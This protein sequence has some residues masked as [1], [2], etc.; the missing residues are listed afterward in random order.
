M[1]SKGDERPSTL[2]GGPERGKKALVFPLPASEH[3]TSIITYTV[4][5]RT[6]W[7]T[8]T[9]RVHKKLLCRA[10]EY[11]NKSLN[12]GFRERSEKKL[13]L[14]HDCPA[15]FEV[16]YNWV[17]T[18]FFYE[19]TKSESDPEPASDLYYLEIY[20]FADCRLIPHLKEHV[21]LLL[22]E[23]YNS[24]IGYLPCPIFLERL[25][26][27]DE[28][29]AFLRDYFVGHTAFW[30]REPDENNDYEHY[31]EIFQA[32]EVKIAQQVALRLAFWYSGDSQAKRCHP[33]KEPAFEEARAQAK[34]LGYAHA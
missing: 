1:S 9:F 11:F 30:L 31:E 32:C 3:C 19:E 25:F 27:I 7:P 10:S 2:Q 13:E 4:G 15:A 22:S 6:Q 20:K 23:S 21:I 5:S 34:R 29:Q 33:C 12:G 8:R 18:G 16:L 24:K 17:Y 14:P 28:E 26:G